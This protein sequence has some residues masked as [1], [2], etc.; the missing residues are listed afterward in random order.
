M[1]SLNI[2]KEIEQHSESE[3]PNECN[4]LIVKNGESYQVFRCKNLSYHPCDH[5]ILSPLDYIN[6]EKQGKIVAYYHSQESDFASLMDSYTSYYQN[7]FSII[8]C[9]KSK[10]FYVLEPKLKDYLNKDF[11][12]G[13]NDCFSLVCNYYKDNLGIDIGNYYRN[14][15]WYIEDSGIIKRNIEKENFRIVKDVKDMEINDIILFGDKD[16]IVHM[17]IYL[18]NDMLLHHPRHGKSSIEYMNHHYKS[19]IALI[20]RHNNYE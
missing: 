14:N 6:A 19:R 7:I 5:S 12:I 18:G 10:K 20:V 15:N 13:V 2:R 8:Y 4:G 16:D 3:F 11:E 9:W 17:G 1:L